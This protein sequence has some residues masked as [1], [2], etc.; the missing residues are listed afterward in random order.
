MNSRPYQH[1]DHCDMG[2]NNGSKKSCHNDM[3]YNTP[4]FK[5]T[6]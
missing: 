1:I 3:L 5:K 6:T 2:K 4:T